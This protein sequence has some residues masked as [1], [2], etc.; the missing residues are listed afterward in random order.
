MRKYNY[1]MNTY[2]ELR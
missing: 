2:G 1:D